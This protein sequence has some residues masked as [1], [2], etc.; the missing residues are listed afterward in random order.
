MSR[1]LKSP[2]AWALAVAAIFAGP[3]ASPAEPPEVVVPAAGARPVVDG[4]LE[5]AC[6]KEAAEIRLLSG[7]KKGAT[8]ARVCRDADQLYVAVVSSTAGPVPK[9][10]KKED[11]EQ[12]ALLIN[13]NG[14]GNSYYLVQVHPDGTAETSYREENPPWYDVTWR[15]KL[16]VKVGSA[17][18][19]WVAEIA[20][21]F[22]SFSMNRSLAPVVGFNLRRRDAAN[23]E[24]HSWQPEF[25]RPGAAG[26]L[27]GIPAR[28]FP[29]ADADEKAPLKLGPGSAHPGTT[30][31]VRLELEG[32]LMGGDPNSRGV[33]WDL[34]VNEKTGELYVLSVP[35]V[36]NP[37]EVQ[38]FDRQGKYLRT[39]AP[40]NP[41]LAREKVKDLA[42]ATA[43]EGGTPL[44]IPKHFEIFGAVETSL[45]GE[46]W[47]FPQK[48]AVAP[49]GD[50]ILTNLYRGTVWRLRPDG[51]LPREGW[52]S[53]LSPERNEPFE[54]TV[55][56]GVKHHGRLHAL[57]EWYAERTDSYLPFPELFYPYWSFD[58]DGNLCMSRGL[59]YK[60]SG[61]SSLAKYAVF[62]E[63]PRN[64]ERQLPDTKAVWWR[65]KLLA[66]AKVEGVRGYGFD[67]KE[68]ALAPP[69]GVPG[70]KA[71][72]EFV[73]ECGLAFDGDHL[74]LSD[75]KEGRLLVFDA[76]RRRVAVVDQYRAEGKGVPFSSPGALA[77]DRQGSIYVLLSGAEK[78]VIKLRSW[79]EPELL[80]TSPKLHAE[81]LQIALDRAAAPPILWVANGDGLGSLVKLSGD[82]L[83][84]KGKWGDTGEALSSPVQQGYVPILNIDPESGHLYIEDDS[85]F[86]FGKRGETYR[87]DQDGR[88]LKRMSADAKEMPRLE[89]LHGK[90]GK[91][92]WW[93]AGKVF[94][95]DRS[96]KPLAFK[97]TGSE[98]LTVD[99]KA[100]HVGVYMGM[101]VDRHGNLY[102]VNAQSG[103]DVFDADGNL[104]M[105]GLLELKGAVRGIQVDHEG[106]IY[107][108]SRKPANILPDTILEVYKSTPLTLSKY[109]SE[110]G[111]PIWSIPWT[112]IT[113]RDQVLVAGCGCLRPRLHQ[114]LDEKGYLF[115]ANWNSIRVIDAA[116]G[117]VV[118]E[119]GSYGN[120]DCQGKGSA[121]PHP[122]LPFG[123]ISAVAVWKDR[124]FAVDV[125]NR[126]IVKCRIVYGK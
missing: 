2:R 23:L 113:G 26:R 105:K 106:K 71:P 20:I 56:I 86:R 28:S 88:I 82:D 21:P 37:S 9:A 27:K 126:R 17:E 40:F 47:H 119:F 53:V 60:A 125:L 93:E 100:H 15:P 95:Y 73:G 107:T 49:D 64:Q 72:G 3:D 5:D 87:L 6:W 31:E 118:G 89:T 25:A 13:S 22:A 42:L 122:E 78:K 77:I 115:A 104:K 69:G 63:I 94:R 32:F 79:R 114:A 68:E 30:G 90:D 67:G 10:A 1:I 92:Y 81:T 103:L 46:W 39:V 59:Q 45:Y 55:D 34:A 76:D 99:K 50:L 120:M 65:M 51:S 109:S 108:L 123:T 121:Y 43:V 74:V 111:D 85:H 58:K 91:L 4:K 70:R 14:D 83:A 116:T 96:G 11:A 66:G 29:S 16:E 7:A 112:G 57:E 44:V 35:R 8:A 52:T 98:S 80:A 101:D 12:V 54:T 97:A 117:K 41:T 75:R 84:L 24:T 102:C 18:R 110:G 61:L 36:R 124:L 62:W 33:I 48:I 38:V 19:E